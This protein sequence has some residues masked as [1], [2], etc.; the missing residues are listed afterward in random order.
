LLHDEVNVLWL[1]SR[2]VHLLFIILLLLLVFVVFIVLLA[3]D[4]L[5]VM[6]MVM[7]VAGVVVG[8]SL[9]AGDLLGSRGLGLGVQILDLS[10]TEDA[11]K[12]S[13]A[14]ADELWGL[15]L[16][17]RCCLRGTCRHQGY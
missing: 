12:M 2:V 11:V 15:I 7:I 14:V 8:L 4:S 3:L 5:V 6:I 9:S 16:T 13:A 10:L 1:K 17:S